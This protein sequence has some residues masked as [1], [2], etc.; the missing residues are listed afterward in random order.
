MSNDD[1]SITDPE[2]VLSVDV[3]W[4][5]PVVLDDIVTALDERG[6]RATFFCTHEEISVPGHERALHPNFRREG[7]TQLDGLPIP[8][9]ELD[10][11]RQ[12]VARAREFCPEAVGVRAHGLFYE[13]RLLSTY[14]AAG[15]EYDSSVLLPLVPGIAPFVKGGDIVELP[16][17][18]MDHWDLV[19]G[20]TTLGLPDLRLDEPGLKVVGF[21]PNLVYLNAATDRDYLDSKPHYD[22]PDWLRHHRRRGRGVR[23]LFHELLDRLAGGPAPPT[24]GDLNARFRG[25]SQ[26]EGGA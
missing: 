2:V 24:L 1:V 5:H 3:E 16:L 19:E 15:L 14:R 13:S 11:Q 23:T 8:E 4:A 7:N 9:S 22:D 26:V 17:Y 21:H 25:H 18:Y 10:F 20:A 12:I 6:L